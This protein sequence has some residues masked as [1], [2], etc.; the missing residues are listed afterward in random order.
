MKNTAHR[1]AGSAE[2]E[3]DTLKHTFVALSRA[4]QFNARS[5][6]Y[7]PLR[8]AVLGVL[9][10]MRGLA[11]GGSLDKSV[12]WEQFEG[13]WSGRGMTEQLEG[14]GLGQG[15][16]EH[17]WRCYEAARAQES[18]ATFKQGGCTGGQQGGRGAGVLLQP[19]GADS[20]SRIPVRSA[21]VALSLHRVSSP[22]P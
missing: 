20:S 3:L 4:A 15:E 22:L 12:G 1:E 8:D 10:W 2:I 17:L 11:E 18:D 5:E 14:A 16:V 9:Q 13:L 6:L 19:A 7:A 21:E